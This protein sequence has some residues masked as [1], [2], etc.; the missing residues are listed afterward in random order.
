MLISPELAVW[1]LRIGHSCGCCLRRML[2]EGTCSESSYAGPT[3]AGTDEAAYV[4]SSSQDEGLQV[5]VKHASF[6]GCV[7]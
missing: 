5:L 3:P 4:L 2:V 1:L 7:H 6:G